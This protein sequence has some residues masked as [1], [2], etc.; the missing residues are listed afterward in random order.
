MR[1]LKICVLIAFFAGCSIPALGTAHDELPSGYITV[2]DETGSIIYETGRKIHPG[3]E[4]INEDNRL[5]EILSV[6]NSRALAV[7]KADLSQDMNLDLALP[8]QTPAETPTTPLISIYHTHTD[9]SYIPTDGKATT[10]GKGS[11]MTVGDVFAAKLSE[12]G[13]RTNHNKTLHEPHDANA[14]QR[15]RRTFVKLLSEQPTALFDLHRDSAPLRYYITRIRGEDVAKLVLVVGRENQN[16][17][18]TKSY[19]KQIKAAAD[20]KYKGLVR[21]IFIAH[22]NYNQDIMPRSMLVEVGT[23]YNSRNAAEKSIAYFAETVPLFI[24]I[25]QTAEAAPDSAAGPIVNEVEPPP[26]PDAMEYGS[27]IAKI[28][29]VVA[30]GVGLY[31]YLST[32]SW[33]KL[34]NKIKHF[35]KVEFTNFLGPLRRRRKK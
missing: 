31:L 23:Q 5:Y 17:N 28:L 33:R 32:G 21:G 2:V 26:P 19:A 30:S 18:T 1:L 29:A 24:K 6:D 12:I 7:Y 9:E 4:F 16:L 34:K 8:A 22:G 13:Y 35:R 15:S 11:I 14:Y 3:D 10:P 25:P 20:S 27:D